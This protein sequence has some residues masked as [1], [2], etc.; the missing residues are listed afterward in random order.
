MI[1][2]E[3]GQY[4]V[5]DSTGK[6]ILGKHKRLAQAL[7]QLAAIEISKKRRAGHEVPRK[8]KT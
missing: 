5:K 4:V 2:K 3:H 7:A 8:H 6:R 1:R